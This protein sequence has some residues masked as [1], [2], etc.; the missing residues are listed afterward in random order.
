MGSIEWLAGVLFVVALLGGLAAPVLALLGIAAPI[1]PLDGRPGHLVGVVLYALGVVGTLAAQLAMGD[2]WRIGVDA[3]E[4]TALVTNGPFAWVRNPIFPAM[5]PTSLGLALMVPSW[6]ALA[7]F[8]VL[9][10][11][12]ELQVRGVEEP[13]LSRVHGPS[14]AAYAARV[15]RFVP[16]LGR[17]RGA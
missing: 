16:G 17:L 1:A 12:L 5:I 3:K 13:Y 2:S 6:V 10:V 9:V 7:A 8:G 4:R 11:A 15:G 14:Y